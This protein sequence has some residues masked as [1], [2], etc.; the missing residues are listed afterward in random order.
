MEILEQTLNFIHNFFVKEVYKGKFTVENGVLNVEFLKPDQYCKIIGSVFND[1]VYRYPSD[2][3]I[4]E[5]F[6][7]EVWAMAVPP[8][9]LA[10][11]S[12]IEGWVAKYG[13]LLNSPYQSESFG[14]YSYSKATG[15]RGKDGTDKATYDWRD[16]FGSQLNQWRKII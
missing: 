12:E 4:D 6:E 5:V 2:E 1:K 13:E 10:L 16:V 3:L 9:L 11:A 8:G 15:A 14:G 7:G